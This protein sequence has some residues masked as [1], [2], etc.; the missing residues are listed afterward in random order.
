MK[1]TTKFGGQSGSA[2]SLPSGATPANFIDRF[3]QMNQQE[4]MIEMKKREIDRK[5][6]EKRAD[7]LKAAA[8]GDSSA[9]KK[10]FCPE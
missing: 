2:A 1:K 4:R 8:A 9:A 6:Q 10:V 5:E 7:D 3:R